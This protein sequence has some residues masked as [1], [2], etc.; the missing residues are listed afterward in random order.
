MLRQPFAREY[1]ADVRELEAI[2]SKPAGQAFNCFDKQFTPLLS[3]GQR[4]GSEHSLVEIPVFSVWAA[5]WGFVSRNQGF[6]NASCVG[7]P[8]KQGRRSASIRISAAKFL[9]Y[10]CPVRSKLI[11]VTT[12]VADRHQVDPT[13]FG[14]LGLRFRGIS[15]KVFHQFLLS[16]LPKCQSVYCQTVLQAGQLMPIPA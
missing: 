4:L 15:L 9:Q 16:R 5:T 8:K 2:Y 12:V 10:I 11:I 1:C 14:H 6:A 7:C 3:Y 13:R